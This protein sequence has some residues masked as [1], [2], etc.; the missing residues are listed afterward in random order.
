MFFVIILN[1]PFITWSHRSIQSFWFRR[2]CFVHAMWKICCKYFGVTKGWAVGRSARPENVNKR[3][4]EWIWSEKM[5]TRKPQHT[6]IF[7]HRIDVF[8]A[9]IDDRCEQTHTAINKT[10]SRIH[11][12][13]FITRQIISIFIT[14]RDCANQQQEL[15]W[16][17]SHF[18]EFSAV[19]KFPVTDSPR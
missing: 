4:F 18:D 7:I 11:A 10:N 16:P 8:F 13:I 14:R 15:R 2:C 6:R 9:R 3:Y 5:K 12:L 19:V 17:H 1:L